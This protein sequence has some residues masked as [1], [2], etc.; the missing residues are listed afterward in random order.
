MFDRLQGRP[1][2]ARW[3]FLAFASGFATAGSGRRRWRFP[4]RCDGCEIQLAGGDVDRG[5]VDLQGLSQTD[6]PAGILAHQTLRFAVVLP[7]IG[8]EVFEPNQTLN[9]E[10]LTLSEDAKSRQARYHTVQLVA[11]ALAEHLENQ[12]ADELSF[13]ILRPLLGEADVSSDLRQI[14]AGSRLPGG[15]RAALQVVLQ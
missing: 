5:D 12:Y 8:A 13:G 10:L 6:G 7:I 15:L 9:A 11:D 1:C 4:E 14:L 3:L 2:G